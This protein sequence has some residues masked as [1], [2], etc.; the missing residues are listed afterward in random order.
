ML[1]KVD[2]DSLVQERTEGAEAERIHQGVHWAAAFQEG[3]GLEGG[4]GD[5]LVGKEE[6]LVETQ[7]SETQEVVG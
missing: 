4:M 6:H 2:L 3:E 5:G 7:A 1:E